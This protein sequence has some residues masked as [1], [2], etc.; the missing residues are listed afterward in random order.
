MNGLP[1][2]CRVYGLPLAQGRPRA[3]RFGSGVRVYDPATSRDW[4][5]TIQ[6]QVLTIKPTAPFDCPLA[7]ELSFIFPRPKSLPKRVLHH[8]KRPDIDNLFK[9]VSD[10]LN[11][12]LYRDDSLIV[13][14]VTRK[15]YGEEPGVAIHLY[16]LDAQGIILQPIVAESRKEAS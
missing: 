12:I 6:A 5:R 4:K 1:F 13:Q 9:A 7:M 15:V 3:A 14:L 11:G 2:H 16:E 8:T 10:A